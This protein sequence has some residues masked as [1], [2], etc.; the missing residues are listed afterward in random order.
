MLKV[1]RKRRNIFIQRIHDQAAL[2]LEGMDILVAYMKQKDS[3]LAEQLTAKEKEADEARRML[4][5]ELN[6]TFITPFDREDIFSLSRAID[7]I[8]DYAYSTVTEIIIFKIKPTEY[9]VQICTLL[10]DA[11]FEILKAVECLQEHPGVAAQHA[12]RAKKIE[13]KVETFYRE[14]LAEMFREANDVPSVVKAMKMREVYRHLSNAA[15]RGDEAA[16]VL[17]N[18]I[19]KTT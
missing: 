8:L 9:M 1:F 18:I 3:S 2:T 19:V 7:D 6:R 15:D 13:N 11:T 16:N 14:A 12:Q 17:A 4:I 10:R 5:D